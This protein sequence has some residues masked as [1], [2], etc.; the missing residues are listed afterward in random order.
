MKKKIEK[1][2]KINKIQKKKLVD[3]VFNSVAK[4]YDFMND[5][6]SYG[7]HRIWKQYTIKH[8][9][10]KNKMKILDLAS[11]T[12]D[13]SIKIAKKIGKKGKIILTDINQIML[14]IGR[15]KLRNLGIIKNIY[16]IQANAENLPF[17]SNYF[18]CI[19]LSF[20]LRN[21]VNQENAL[22]SIFRILKPGGRL[23]I[24]EFSK[25][26]YSL[27]SKIFNIYSFYLL[28]ILGK[29]FVNDSKSYQYLAESIY[30]HP[31]QNILKKKIMSI[32]F[33]EVSYIN[34]FG[35]I[36]ALH[37]CFKL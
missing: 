9:G 11:G 24:L 29:I 3:S 34:I 37:K 28:P 19:V 17:C 4:K 5:I 12:G 1:L 18:D 25:P 35:G 10:I 23:L 31:N 30:L 6:M 8:I 21:I 16:Y 2:K 36:V 27:L 32:G 15:K 22:K 7:L 33:Q 13:L 14:N 20:G 26:T